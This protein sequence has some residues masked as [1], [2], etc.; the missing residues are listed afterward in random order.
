MARGTV[1]WS[2]KSGA[3]ISPNTGARVRVMF[4]EDGRLDMRADL[5]D[6]EVAKLVK[7][8]KFKEVEARP[9]RRGEKRIRI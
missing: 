7:D 3:Q 4:Y 2:D 8:Y 5:T 9:T 1:L 6:D